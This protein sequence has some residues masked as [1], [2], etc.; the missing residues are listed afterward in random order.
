MSV[1]KVLHVIPSVGPLRGG[2][3]TMVRQLARNLVRAGIETHVATTDDNAAQVLAV[4]IGVPVNQD[5]VTYW[6][7]RRQTRFYTISWP[8]ASWLAAHVGDYDVVHIHALF[9]FAT[10]PAARNAHRCGVPYIVRPL[11]TLNSW[12]M[13]RRRPWLKKASFKLI[14]SRVVR[15][16]A[17]VHYTSEQERAEAGRLG[18]DTA[19]V[20]IPNAV[21]NK[22]TDAGTGACPGAGRDFSHAEAPGEVARVAAWQVGTARGAFRRQIER[23][24]ERPVVLFLSRIDEK[25]GLDLLLRAFAG[26]RERVPDAL[27]VVAGDGAPEFVDWIRREAAALDLGDDSVVWT[28]FVTGREKSA[29]LADADVFVLPS[30]SE[31]FGLAVAEAMAAR[32]PVV[33]S[34]Q[35]G[36]HEEIADEGAGLVVPCD[37]VRLADALETLLGSAAL[38]QTMGSYG[39]A[40]VQRLYSADAVTRSVIDAYNRV[41]DGAA[42]RRAEVEQH[43]TRRVQAEGPEADRKSVV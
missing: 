33:V 20:V 30:Y 17:L 8:L 24:R 21:G 12:G 29:L 43:E 19:S 27:L 28:G 5:G 13:E 1:S 42:E 2:P 7:F 9:S 18:V 4:P 35:I 32:L 23:G 34:D 36:I 31:N 37:A 41:V 22:E 14:E 11:G 16:A 25:K 40:L 10:L 6:F 26:L 3:S 15:H 38:R 39:Q